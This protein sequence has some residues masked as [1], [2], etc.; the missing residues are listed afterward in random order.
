MLDQTTPKGRILSAALGCAA[1]K[2]WTDVTLLDIAEAAKLSLA[3][4]RAEFATKIGIVAALLRAVDDEVLRRA[5]QRSE[6]QERRD[7]LFDIVMTRFDVLGPHKA[8]LKSI[9]DSGSADFALA[10]PYLSS[11]HWMLEAAGI[12]TDG[13]T[14]ALRVAGLGLAYA[15][16]FRA[17]LEDDDPGLARTMAALDRRLRR[18]ERAISGFEQLYE[19]ASRFRQAL[20]EAARTATRDRSK[21]EATPGPQAGTV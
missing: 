3:D 17:W 19:A 6:G 1:A 16:V 13:T 2:S 7:R 12:G 4:L 5:P 15:S 14:G 9:H 8:A 20:R 18:G 11:Q 10:G 21:P